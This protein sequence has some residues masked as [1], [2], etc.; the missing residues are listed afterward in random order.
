MKRFWGV[1]WLAMLAQSWGAWAQPAEPLAE[2]MAWVQMINGAGEQDVNQLCTLPN[3]DIAL[4]GVCEE[5]KGAQFTSRGG[6][7]QTLAGNNTTGARPTMFVARYKPNGALLWQ[8]SIENARTSSHITDLQ[9]DKQGNIVLCGAM[10]GRAV[11]HAADGS[12]RVVPPV[13]NDVHTYFVAKYSGSGKLLWLSTARSAEQCFAQQLLTDAENNVY[14]RAYCSPSAALMLDD[15]ALLQPAQNAENPRFNGFLAKY[16]PAGKLLWAR[17]GGDLHLISMALNA[18]HGGVSLL[19]NTSSTA[20]LKLYATDQPATR[21]PRKTQTV[22]EQNWLDLNGNGEFL[23]VR[24]AFA[25][26][27]ARPVRFQRDTTGHWFVLMESAYRS[28][29]SPRYEFVAGNLRRTSDQVSHTFLVKCTPDE[30]PLWVAEIGTNTLTRPLSLVLDGKGNVLVGCWYAWQVCVRS[31]ADV[32]AQRPRS[33]DSVML[34]LPMGEGSVLASFQA[35]TGK[36][37]GV[38]TLGR[39]ARENDGMVNPSLPLAADARGN[40]FFG[41]YMNLGKSLGKH[42]VSLSDAANANV[43][44]SPAQYAELNWRTASDG[45]FGC[46][47]ENLPPDPAPRDTTPNQQPPLAARDTATTPSLAATLAS[48]IAAAADS[49]ADGGADAQPLFADV[50]LFPNPVQASQRVVN[51]SLTLAERTT[52][53]WEITDLTGRSLLRQRETH[54]AGN[55]QQQFSLENYAAGVYV[56]TLTAGKIVESK[57]IV[58]L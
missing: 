17:H 50:V 40:V 4:A 20:A 56:L 15:V 41:G 1:M 24:P 28:L 19:Y 37:N 12:E 5:A 58:V 10:G 44:L 34:R 46:I 22:V 54:E 16:S 48:D 35:E 9:T 26:I 32:Q 30:K 43:A 31:G 39:M 27:Q 25:N 33:A 36:L 14:V 29:G 47:G 52:I 21:I 53:V 7:A 49:A 57:G 3:G 38:Q 42:A 51:V 8:I 45:F 18:T 55:V 23:G 6:R 11:F 13:G 2:K